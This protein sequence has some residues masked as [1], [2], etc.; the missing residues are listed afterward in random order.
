MIDHGTKSVDGLSGADGSPERFS[1]MP[2]KV[3]RSFPALCGVREAGDRITQARIARKAPQVSRQSL[4]ES[5]FATG[6]ARLR[7]LQHIQ[8]I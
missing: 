4:S 3:R 1:H 8:S 5:A 6:L 7:G 2:Q